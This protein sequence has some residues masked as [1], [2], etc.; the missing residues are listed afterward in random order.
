MVAEEWGVCGAGFACA[1]A[2]QLM[3]RYRNVWCADAVACDAKKVL[4]NLLCCR[5]LPNKSN[6]SWQIISEPR[7][8][9]PVSIVQI[10]SSRVEKTC[11]QQKT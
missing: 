11:M 5:V 8:G 7:F 10:E 9:C 3:L 6:A 4:C 1:R 2:E